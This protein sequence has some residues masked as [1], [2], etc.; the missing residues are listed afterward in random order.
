M[1][2]LACAAA[3]PAFA[4]TATATAGAVTLKPL[5]VVKLRDLDFGRITAS[6]SAGTVSIDPDTKTRST[7]GGVVAAGGSPQSA[8]FMTYG[9]P[10]K[11]MQVSR[12]ALPV[13][14]RV[15]GG[16]TMAVTAI[17]L[18]GDTTKFLNAAGLFDLFVGGTLAVAAN[19]A[20]G[21]YSGTFD[22]TFTY[23]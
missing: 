22:I 11:T 9:S 18:N 3:G 5:A 16:A 14:T 2:A 7:T 21:T 4:G 20:D 12:G 13:L 10:G 1:A 6:A 23:Y 17:T 19:Q 8:E 15:G